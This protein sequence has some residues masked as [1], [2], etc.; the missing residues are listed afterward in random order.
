[1]KRKKT[2]I[3]MVCAILWGCT[4]TDG[5]V[6]SDDMTGETGGAEL[7]AGPGA[8]VSDAGDVLFSDTVQLEEVWDL[9]P[10]ELSEVDAGIQP[11]LAGYPCSSPG[12]CVWAFASRLPVESAVPRVAWRSVR[13]I[14][15]AG[16][17]TRGP[18]FCSSASRPFCHYAAP[19]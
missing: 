17:L 14:G 6:V 3:W 18:I 9:A 13:S 12:D 2:S 8:V 1:M 7:S 5:L 19:A 16:S 15:S 11:G 4:G 10:A